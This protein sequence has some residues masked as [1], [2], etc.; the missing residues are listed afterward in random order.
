MFPHKGKPTGK[1]ASHMATFNEDEDFT[2]SESSNEGM[3]P[4]ANLQ[5]AI[6]AGKRRRTFGGKA[7]MYKRAPGKRRFKPGVGTL[8]EIAFYQHEYGLLCSKIASA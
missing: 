1:A 5:Q 4:N 8:K 3:T 2:P 6:K 7:W